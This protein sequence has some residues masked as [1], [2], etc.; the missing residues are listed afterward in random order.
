MSRTKRAGMGSAE[1]VPCHGIA[2]PESLQERQ[3]SQTA[4][5]PPRA[6][7]DGTCSPSFKV[8]PTLSIVGERQRA[9]ISTLSP[10]LRLFPRQP[11]GCVTLRLKEKKISSSN[12]RIV[13][14][15]VRRAP[16]SSIHCLRRLGQSKPGSIQRPIGDEL[17]YFSSL[18]RHEALQCMFR[19]PCVFAS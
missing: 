3:S 5:Y 18:R 4:Q 8:H 16:P 13:D 11:V 9:S 19:A 7:I 14:F 10:P 17:V 12:G 1:R 2:S 15:C 6:Y